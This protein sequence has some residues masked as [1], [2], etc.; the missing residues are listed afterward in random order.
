LP[1]NPDGSRFAGKL[2]AIG[3]LDL[4]ELQAIDPPRRYGRD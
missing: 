3:E 4:E 1:D 2:H